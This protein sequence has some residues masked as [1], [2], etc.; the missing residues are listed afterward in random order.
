M[1]SRLLRASPSEGSEKART[2]AA[3]VGAS[4]IKK[5]PP[6]EAGAFIIN[7]ATSYSPTHLRMQYHRG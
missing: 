3:T 7:R 1:S 5:K 6:I 2:S 4:I